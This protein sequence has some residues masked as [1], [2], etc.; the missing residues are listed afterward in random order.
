ML[1]LH[2]DY[3]HG[4]AFP[5]VQLRCAAPNPMLLGRETQE[6]TVGWWQAEEGE[7]TQ[8][9]LG[10]YGSD[11]DSGLL[12]TPADTFHTFTGLQ[13]DCV[14]SAWVRKACRYTTAGYDTLVWSDWS[15]PLVF[16]TK[17]G[18][19]KVDADTDVRLQPNP[20]RDKV[21]VSSS[22]GLLHIEIHDAAGVL[23]YSEAATGHQKTI[24]I[25]SLRSG[26]Y[27]VTVQTHAGITHKKLAVQRQ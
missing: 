2:S 11:P 3:P 13:P 26:T 6:A 10:P 20:A 4:V 12:V 24:G 16:R 5:I 17:V 25:G 1:L 23:V 9:S 27:I 8:L 22:F 14:Y 19:G 15:R 18:I 7:A 21:T